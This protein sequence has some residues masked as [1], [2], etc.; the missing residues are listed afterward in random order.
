MTIGEKIA[1]ARRAKGWTQEE[2]ADRLGVTRQSVSK[3]ES[4]AALPETDKHVRLCELLHMSCGAPLRPEVGEEAL[5]LPGASSGAP[6]QGQEHTVVGPSSGKAAGS[7]DERAPDVPAA[8]R[9]LSGG[10]V[11]FILLCIVAGL[12]LMLFSS[13]LFFVSA[14][15]A[16]MVELTVFFLVG[17]ALFL[18]GIVVCLFLRRR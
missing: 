12:I 17:L 7:T 3:W 2:L 1:R 14:G 10:A 6:V 16:G 15:Q 5:P 13:V 11:A 9:P 8:G 18:L 4:D